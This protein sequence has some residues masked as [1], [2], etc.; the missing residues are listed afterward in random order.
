M[1][2][3]VKKTGIPMKRTS[4]HDED[5]RP[6]QLRSCNHWGDCKFSLQMRKGGLVR[7]YASVLMEKL[8]YK[9]LCISEDTTSQEVIR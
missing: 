8:K 1:D 3:T 5:A 6:V 2:V 4:V 9:C 7:V